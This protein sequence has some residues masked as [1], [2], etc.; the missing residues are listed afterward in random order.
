MVIRDEAGPGS[1]ELDE[2]VAIGPH[3]RLIPNLLHLSACW[4]T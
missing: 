3:F 4:R 2:A 1:P